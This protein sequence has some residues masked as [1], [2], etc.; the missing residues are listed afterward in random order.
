[1]AEPRAD[2][3][4]VVLVNPP[5]QY[6][7]GVARGADAY[8]RP[9]L[10]IAYLAA[11]LR[12]H[13]GD[14]VRLRLI[15]CEA[16]GFADD[17]QVVA[18]ILSENPDVVGFSTVTGTC[19]QVGDLAAAIKRA[20]P[21]TVTIAGGPHIT[22]LPDQPLAG[23]DVNVAGEGE[24]TLLELAQAVVAGRPPGGIA[25]C[26]VFADGRVVAQ[27]PPRPLMDDIDAV[28]FPAR[29]LL[30]L[31]RYF[32]SY[33]YAGARRFTTLF[34]A[35][36]C[37]FS[38]NF[39][40]NET[41]W[42]GRVRCHSLART[43]AEIDHVVAQ[44]TT[45]I[46]FDDDTFTAD[47]E[48]VVAICRHLARRH[49]HLRWIC[50]AR[51]DT[52]DRD[53]LVTMQRAGCVEVQIGVESGDAEVLRRTDKRLTLDRFAPVFG[54][55]RELGLNSW[56]TFILGNDGETPA[57]VRRTIDF[58]KKL[59]PT[60]ASFIVLLPFPGTR[61][62]AQYDAAGYLTS[63]DW[64]DFSWHGRPV[65]DLPEL[66]VAAL[67]SWRRRAYREFYLRPRKLWQTAWSVLRAA[68]WRE[69]RRNFRAWRV[70][71]R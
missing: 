64:R 5:F 62:F 10:G 50:H 56:A 14:G 21:E 70:L 69:M 18:T 68:S 67:V 45:L 71:A 46:F 12:Q 31:D 23:V 33:P 60:Y 6:F 34:T 57:T 41:V 37:P 40:G 8:T 3:L 32:H 16:E 39:C 58:A 47:R 9:P 63:H 59:D 49:P 35:R 1:M 66:P 19:A 2:A 42:G 52:L 7:P 53:L 29:E 20:R 22:A 13:L 4:R 11:Y 25:G 17:G 54:W 28:P 61:I 15:D 27:G 36:G 65:I 55:L 48:R 44:G 51:G 30:G 24:Q 38:C 43:C 26:T